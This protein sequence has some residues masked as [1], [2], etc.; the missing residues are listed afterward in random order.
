MSTKLVT[1]KPATSLTL[2]VDLPIDQRPALVYL[3]SLATGSRRTMGDA[4]DVIADM[5]HAGAD[6]LS[7]NWAAVRFQHTAAVR[8]A[9]AERYSS[10]TANKMLCALRGV[11][12]AAWRL[13]Q[14]TADDY[15][16]AVDL[17]SVAGSTLPRGRALT[18]GEIS[19]LIEACQLDTSAAGARDAAMIA[20]LRAG[21]L[22]RAEVCDLTLADYNADAGTLIIHGKRNKTREI[23]VANGAVGAL[24]D[25]LTIRGNEPGPIFTP[26]NKG[27]KVIARH[28]HS[29]AIFNMLAKRAAEAGIKNLSPHDFR[30]TFVSDL[31]DAGAD[32]ST[33]QK[34]AGHAN[35]TTT[36]RYDRRGEAAKRKAVDLLHVPYHK[37]LI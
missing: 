29:E 27:G 6:R 10:A 9:L 14:M 22:R 35:V 31:L 32:I 36:A 20:L 1:R 8:S 21:G 18:A 5:L 28:M 30:R 11:L 12:K 13:G 19:G 34:L 4:L 7:I 3:A 23:P 25:W 26:I 37:R 15:T 2:A 16:R 17:P 33:V 24:A